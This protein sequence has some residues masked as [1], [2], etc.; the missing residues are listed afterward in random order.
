MKFVHL[1]VHSFFSFES[2]TADILKLLRRCKQLGMDAVALTDYDGLYGAVR[3]LRHARE[4]GIRPIIGAELTLPESCRILLLA[5]NTEGYSNLCRLISSVHLS[6]KGRPVCT[7]ELLGKYSRNLIALSGGPKGEIGRLILMGENLAAEGALKK[8]LDIFGRDNFFIELQDHLL[9]GGRQLNRELAKFAGNSGAGIVATNN[10]HFLHR[11]EYDLHKALVMT[12][13]AVHHRPELPEPNEEF[14]LKSAAEMCALF[15]EFPEAL[16]NTL[17]IAES[18]KVDIEL[19]KMRPTNLFAPEGEDTDEV[20]EKACRG[21]LSVLFRG[22][23][24]QAEKQ[25]DHELEVVKAKRFADYF[26]IVRDIVN[27]AGANGIRF[28]CRGSASS[29]II[30]YLLGVSQVDPLENDLLFERFLNPERRDIPDIDL[31]FDSRRRDE[32]LDYILAKYGAER[33]CMVATVPTFE[34]RSAVRELARAKGM[35]YEAIDRLTAYLPYLPG[36]KIRRALKLLPELD[37]SALKQR[38]YARLLKFVE[39]IGGFPHHLSVHLGGVVIWDRLADIVPMQISAKGHPV[40]QYDKDDLEALGLIKTDILSLRML[41]ALSEAEELIRAG[42]PAFDADAIPLDDDGTY[43]LLRS[44]RT[45][46][47]FQLESPGMRQLLGRLQPERFSDIIAN[48]SLFRPGPMRADMVSP[49]LARRRGREKITYLH[50]GLEP[51]L[52]ETYGVIVFQEQ[53]LRIS[54]EIAGFSLGQADLFRRAMTEEVT[55]K[56]LADLRRQ[57]VQGARENGIP[58]AVAYGIFGKLAAFASFGF[59]KAHAVSFARLAYES[60]Y[61]KKHYPLE[62]FTGLL[63]NEPGLYPLSVIANEARHC[64]VEVL[65]VDINESNAGFVAAG[66]YIRAGLAHV[67][68]VGAACM[69]KIFSAREN[70]PF[71]GFSDFCGRV[72]V[73]K[74]PLENKILCGAFDRLEANRREL[75]L[76]VRSELTGEEVEDFSAAEKAWFELSLTGLAFT[77]HPIAFL[78]EQL[79]SR[80][81]IR[82]GELERCKDGERITVA[83]LKVVLHTPPTRSGLRVV[84]LTLE[85]EDGLTDVTVFSD[86]Q[87]R[88]ARTVFGR[89]V[90]MVEGRLQRM[91]PRSVTLVADKVLPISPAP[92]SI[93]TPVR[94]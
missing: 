85:D 12:G 69:E 9:P 23:T 81:V 92:P 13:R 74:R 46:G 29:S 93:V 25:L 33:A 20:L 38:R 60:G 71:A 6:A 21:V 56:E 64:G 42:N 10:V 73:R 61:L 48:I 70:G 57:F 55:E 50:P 22:R 89:N 24:M 19:D 5:K 35:S 91:Y 37:A 39:E 90:L 72:R 59:P 87:R 75:F 88:Y 18:C 44:T 51:I 26:L 15:E 16:E 41:G 32:V 84:F 77:G 86:V 94:P 62:F 43:E 79:S 53:V 3:L 4:L 65:G 1:H 63:N 34:A 40:A 31:D 14:Y 36:P 54:R 45:V 2:G 7:I 49:Y 67:T 27:F 82:S 52:K 17:A 11:G 66:R 8:Y 58:A 78:R 30:L 68:G 47:C 28:S 76:R 80:G 83:G